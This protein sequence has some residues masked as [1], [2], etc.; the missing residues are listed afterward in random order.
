MQDLPGSRYGT[1][2]LEQGSVSTLAVHGKDFYFSVEDSAGTTLRNLS[3]YLTSV[4]FNRSND[5]HDNTT[6]GA[7]GHTFQTGLTNGTITLNGFW[8]T[9]ATVGSATVLDGLLDLDSPT[10]GFEYGPAGN[11][12]GL[13]KYSGECIL[14]DLSHSSP[15]ADLVTFSATLQITGTVT[16]GAFSA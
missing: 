8:D 16:K 12:N 4:D 3:P 2:P 13:V 6:S 14:Q 7:E 11:T 10:L 1:V 5:T 15:V 9:T